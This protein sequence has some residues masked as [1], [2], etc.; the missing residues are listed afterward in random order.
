MVKW[1]LLWGN[2]LFN[3]SLS[4]SR[5][6]L[7]GASASYLDTVVYIGILFSAIEFCHIQNEI[8]DR[9]VVKSWKKFDIKSDSNLEFLCGPQYCRY[10]H[11]ILK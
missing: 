3:S 2:L 1:K 11:T 4:K 10:F 9:T 8:D 6:S 5:L 7:L